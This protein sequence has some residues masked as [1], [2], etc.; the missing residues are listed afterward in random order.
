MPESLDKKNFIYSLKFGLILT[1][2]FFLFHLVGLTR[3]SFWIDELHTY[4]SSKLPI[5][6]LVENRF[7]AGHLPLYFLF[8]KY[9]CSVVGYSEGMMRFPSVV[10]ASL[11]FLAFFLLCKKFLKETHTFTVAI[12]LFFFHPFVFW[13]S[14]EARMYSILILITILSSYTFLLFIE[15]SLERDLS[16]INTPLT[17]LERGLRHKCRTTYAPTN[18]I[19]YSITILI[20]M[21]LHMVFILQLAVHFIYLLIYHRKQWIKL[22]LGIILPLL[23]L[24]PMLLTYSSMQEKYNPGI[25]LKL[26]GPGKAIK[27]MAY[28]AMGDPQPFFKSPE[29]LH[30]IFN[31]LTVF[32]FLFFLISSIVYYKKLK[33]VHSII[34]QDIHPELSSKCSEHRNTFR[35]RNAQCAFPTNSSFLEI[36]ILRYS[37]YWVGISVLIMQLMAVLS[38]NKIGPTRYYIPMLAPIVII[39]AIGCVKWRKYFIMNLARY[40]FLATFLVILFLQFTWKGVGVREGIKFLNENYSVNDGVVYCSDGALS[41]S[42]SFYNAEGMI[43]TGISKDLLD[44][45]KLLE[46]VKAFAQGKKRLWLILYRENDSP[47]ITLLKEHPELFKQSFEEEIQE[48]KIRGFEVRDF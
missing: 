24:S 22:A 16:R 7:K 2:L 14:Q 30:D 25:N 9:W 20:G 34:V 13:A 43:R 31:W 18:L 4:G 3:H 47:L 48:V 19:T 35:K 44:K 27:R 5:K 6:E 12:L 41:Y 1:L 26:I 10:F 33:K 37:F 23:I 15:K 28:I 40:L 42:F 8:I 45:E 39:M 46:K 36:S 38:Y 17:P 21:S 29:L 11:S 32:F